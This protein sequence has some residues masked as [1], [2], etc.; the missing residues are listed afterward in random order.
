VVDKYLYNLL[1]F[2]Y[3]LFKKMLIFLCNVLVSIIVLFIK[4][5]SN[6][7]IIGGWYGYRFADNSMYLYAYINEFTDK[8]AIWITKD[9][10]IK[11]YLNKKGLHAYLSWDIKGIYYQLK[12]KYHIVDQS[13]QDINPILSIGAVKLMLWHGVPIKRLSL[14]YN[15]KSK[16]IINLIKS[17]K[18]YKLFVPGFWDS[19]NI[20]ILATSWQIVN[21]M[22]TSFPVNSNNIIIANYPRN[23]ATR[24]FKNN[25]MRYLSHSLITILKTV[26]ILKNDGYI[27]LGYFPTFRDWGGDVFFTDNYDKLQLFLRYLSDNKVIVITKFHFGAKLFNRNLCCLKDNIYN[28]TN[29]VL[30]DE[31]DDMN[32]VLPELDLLISD[33]SGVIYDFLWYEK[34]IILYPYDLERYKEG[35]GFSIDYDS[36][37]PGK[38]VYNICELKS[39]IDQFLG[40]PDYIEKYLPEIRSIRSEIFETEVSC[41]RII[42]FLENIK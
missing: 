6:I 16:K 15:N 40:D 4:R 9:E 22:T 11:E 29:V 20:C 27:V 35:R 32:P 34:P 10:N 38:K 3:K 39:E 24:Y 12:A 5:N 33:Y 30:I 28:Y 23:E 42:N 13:M 7:Y 41:K 1:I 21:R 17:F 36:F 26:S 31:A 25:I 37:N 14:Y 19:K 2:I 18:S 8:Q